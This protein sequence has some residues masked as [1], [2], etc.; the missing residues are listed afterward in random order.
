MEMQAS[1]ASALTMVARL[2]HPH[3]TLLRLIPLLWLILMM[4][5][6]K[7]AMNKIKSMSETSQR[8]PRHLFG[9]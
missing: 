7:K 8:H 2:G 5:K 6:E 4:M 9:A 3:L 1:A